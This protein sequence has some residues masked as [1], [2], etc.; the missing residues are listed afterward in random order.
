MSDPLVLHDGQVTKIG[1][2]LIH[3]SEARKFKIKG[4]MESCRS[5]V[6]YTRIVRLKDTGTPERAPQAAADGEPT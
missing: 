6:S 5:T 4:G 3:T 2:E 1:R